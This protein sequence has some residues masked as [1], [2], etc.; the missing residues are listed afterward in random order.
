MR[1][2]ILQWWRG[3]AAGSCQ[4]ERIEEFRADDVLAAFAAIERQVGNAG[5][6]AARHPRHERRIL[7]VGMR[8]GVKSTRRRRQAL[9]RERQAASAAIVDGTNLC[10]SRGEAPTGKQ[11]GQNRKK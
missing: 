3:V 10:P 9:Q 11:D 8:A 1:T 4:L 2:L 5:V 7:I 6:I